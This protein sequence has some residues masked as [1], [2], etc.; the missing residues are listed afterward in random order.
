MGGAEEIA[1]ECRRSQAGEP[2][3]LVGLIGARWRVLHNITNLHGNMN[4]IECAVVKLAQK[5]SMLRCESDYEGGVID[6]R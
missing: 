6:D 4:C 1:E 3:L 5:N 2:V